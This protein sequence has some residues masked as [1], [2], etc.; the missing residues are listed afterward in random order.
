MISD[1][2]IMVTMFQFVDLVIN[3]PIAIPAVTFTSGSAN[4]TGT[5]FTTFLNPGLHIKSSSSDNWYT[6][7]TVV[8]NTLAILTALYT[9]ITATQTAYI[10]TVGK[11]IIRS[12]Q[13]ISAPNVDNYLIIQKP[14]AVRKRGLMGNWSKANTSGIVKFTTHY[15]ATI[16]I[17]EE[18]GTG[19]T[20][21]K[22]ITATNRQD[23]KDFFYGKKISIL[24]DVGIKPLNILMGNEWEDR[25]ILDF[26]ILF[27]DEDTYIPGYIQ[28][29]DVQ[30]TYN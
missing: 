14:F 28:T 29:T 5:G 16:T 22:L 9:D 11:V 10:S 20:L 13:N 7:Q 3:A 12:N 1:D 2:E 25:A 27:T 24:A 30:G 6:V 4:I 8:S 26:F 18:K 17:E 21:R 19:Q 15:E 23:V